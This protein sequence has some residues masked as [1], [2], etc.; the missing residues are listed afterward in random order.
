[1]KQNKITKHS[2]IR[3]LDGRR[4]RNAIFASTRQLA[5]MQAYLNKINV[6][7]VPDGD[8][9]TNMV[10]TMNHISGRL[11][12]RT[13]KSI[14]V[15]SSQMA[16]SA[17]MGA[18]G[19]S[20]AI[21]AQF[22]YGF[23]E[24]VKDKW[25]LTTQAFA[26]AVQRAKKAAYEALSEPR[27]GTI[28]TV[29][30]DWADYIEKAASRTEDFVILLKHGLKRAR[31]SLAETPKK[32]DVLRKAG[33]VDAG[34]QGFVHFLEGIVHF[35]EQGK[36]EKAAMVQPARELDAAPPIPGAVDSNISF[37]FCTEAMVSAEQIDHLELR[38]ALMPLGDSLIVAGSK[39]HVRVHIHTNSPD[40]VFEIISA[41]GQ[42]SAKKVDDMIK[43]HQDIYSTAPATR[44]GIVTD[45]S[46]D[47]PYDFI[48]KHHIHVIPMKISFGDES[49][50][51]KVNI[52]PMEFYDKL[53]TSPHHP[54]SSQPALADVLKVYQQVVPQYDAILSIHLP[55]VVS[56]S[57]QTI[58][59]AAKMVDPEKITCIDGK[60]ISAALGLVVMEAVAAI[61]EGL[62]LDQVKSR[63]QHAI[64][65][66]RIFIM[67][68]TLKYLVRGGRMSKPKGLIGTL[69]GLK[70][71]VTFDREGRVVLAGK[72][73][74]E[75]M[76]MN[77]TL[78]MASR[79]LRKFKR[80]KFVVAHANAYAKA[81][82][83][84]HQLTKRFNLKE[85]I[86]I[87]DAAP[88][89]GVHSGPGTVGF[90]VIG[91]EE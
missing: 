14:A 5:K 66:I 7:P 88:V 15:V 43:Q 72:A 45:S 4:L 87:V 12:E 85:S 46:C 11:A 17:L 58:E 52:T 77:K 64:E 65:N 79:F 78:T 42:I 39:N 53:L 62:T 35:I 22:F 21:L 76:A 40:S 25:R 90:A 80:V 74:G 8:T 59:R 63:V 56:G 73:I 32:L 2:Q 84:V 6:F 16:E 50:L 37:R 89:L 49:Y 83:Y 34:A 36:I 38:K 67:L 69:L 27:D 30:D 19:N 9:G 81:T 75:K 26:A 55:K 33:V 86:P 41:H 10:R 18:Q 48:T 29:I 3:Y 70:P 47:L 82:W 91:Y 57:F 51:D 60:G 13:D 54:T 61:E 31:L 20:G 24:A 23:A 44:I 71:I 1:M 68:P 28:L